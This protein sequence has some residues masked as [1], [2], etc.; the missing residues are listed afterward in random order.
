MPRR[1][2]RPGLLFSRPLLSGEGDLLEPEAEELERELELELDLEL[3]PDCWLSDPDS[4]DLLFLARCFLQLTPEVAA[5]EAAELGR[6]ALPGARRAGS[7]FSWP[8]PAAYWDC[9]ARPARE[10]FQP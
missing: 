1:F 10:S 2:A 4:L 6:P 5:A 8:G 7:C 9:S 3:E